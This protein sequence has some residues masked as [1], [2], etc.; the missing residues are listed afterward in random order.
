[1]SLL[2]TFWHKICEPLDGYLWHRDIT[3]HIVRPALRNQILASGAALLFGAFLYGAF[4]WL[5]WFGAG[6]LA[7][8]WIFWSWARFFLK[9]DISGYSSAFLRAVLLRFGLRFLFFAFLLYISLAWAQAPA[10]A[11]LAGMA[12]GAFLAI[13]S[14]G[15]NVIVLGRQ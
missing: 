5:F 6:L 8:T 11:I 13:A 2:G 1:M 9:T 3:H 10:S 15:Y 4:P 14:Y 7:I 12:A